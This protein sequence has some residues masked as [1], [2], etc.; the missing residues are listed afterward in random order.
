MKK[1]IVLIG[2]G[3]GLS[4]IAKGFKDENVNLNIIVSSMDDGG[5]TGKIRNEFDYVAVGDL[6]MVLGELMGEQSALKDL[7]NYR[8]DRLHG[9]NGVSLGNLIITALL[10]KYLSIDKAIEYLKDKEKI[11]HNI[12]LSSNNSLTLCAECENGEIIRCE[13]KIGVSNKKIRKLFIDKEAQCNEKMIT[14]I[15]KSEVIVLCPGS[16]YTSVG[17]VLCIDKIRK[18]ICNSKAK[19][20][21]VCN[22]MCQDGET[23]GFSVEDHIHALESILSRKIDNIIVNNGEIEES[24]LHK[25]RIENSEIVKVKKEN[26]MYE[27][28]DL[29]EIIDG[30]VRHNSELVKKIILDQQ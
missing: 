30:K 14:A 25:Y 28:Y 7:F 24:I 19:V 20:I 29:V 1:S 18:A 26:D 11:K 22:I 15:E 16:L 2:G 5:H 23:K 21:Y 4:N 3:H 12:Y 9:T 8:F 10:Q 6:R 27:F 17:S 13:N